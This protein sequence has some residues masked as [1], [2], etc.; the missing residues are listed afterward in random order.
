[1]E[2]NRTQLEVEDV[3]FWLSA[4]TLLE[5]SILNLKMDNLVVIRFEAIYTLSVIENLTM[6]KKDENFIAS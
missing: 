4:V 6:L 2:Q 1:M 3:S 5:I